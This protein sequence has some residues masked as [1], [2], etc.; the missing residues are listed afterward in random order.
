MTAPSPA[1]T[2]ELSRLR[3]L[4]EGPL[5]KASYFLIVQLF[6]AAPPRLPRN[7]VCKGEILLQE[8]RR[9]L[10][11]PQSH[12]WLIP[13]I[14]DGWFQYSEVHGWL[15]T[16]DFRTPLWVGEPEESIH[17]IS[18]PQIGAQTTVGQWLASRKDL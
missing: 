4:F 6:S 8:S 13:C 17:A 16:L 15:R 11:E 14:P 18:G 5:T 3:V 12:F 7:A 1:I 10:R 2:V 9:G